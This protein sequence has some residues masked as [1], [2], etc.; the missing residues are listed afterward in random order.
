[1]HPGV[2]VGQADIDFVRAKIAAGQEPWKS[3]LNRVL[4]SGSSIATAARPTTRYSSLSYVPA[5]VAIIQA[6]SAT[7]K[8]YIAAHP[9]Y[10]F[11]TI[12]D[13]EHLDDARSAYAHALLWAYTGNQANANKAIEIMNAWSGKLTEIKFDQPRRPDNGTQLYNN[14]ML[15]AGWG[16]SLFARAAE[17]IRYTG[18]GW[19]TSDVTRFESMLRNVYLPLTIGSWNTGTNGIMTWAEA[20][21]AIGVFTNDRAAFDAGVATWRKKTPM[22]IYMPSDGPRPIAPTAYWDTDARM[23]EL[24]HQPSS[25]VAGLEVETLRDLSHMAMGLGAMTNAAQ[26]AALQGVDL[27]GEQRARIVAG[28]ELHARYINEYLDKVAALGGAAVPTTWR[29]TGWLGSTFTLGGDGYKH[30]WEVA[31]S[32]YAPLGVSM[33]NTKRLVERVR[34]SGTAL[35]MS[36]ETL[37]H[38]R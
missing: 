18:A 19:V 3:A 24:W 25:Y 32:H 14:G 7:N 21:I 22:S 16:G 9:E 12:G 11:A 2:L 13:V 38:A 27:F 6:P 30:G 28:Y 33:P 15:Q 36:W 8:A 23:K 35:H 1:M 29:P 17:I 20:T 4:T 5:P 26:T 10:G 31:Y 37:S 34:P